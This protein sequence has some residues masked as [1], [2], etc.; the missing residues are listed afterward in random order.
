MLDESDIDSNVNEFKI[1]KVQDADEI[2]KYLPSVLDL[3]K[4][5]YANVEGGFFGQTNP[6]LLKK[7]ISMLQLVFDGKRII[8]G[9]MCKRFQESHKVSAMFCDQTPAG[10][11]AF[12]AVIRENI[13]DF[14]NW[15][16]CE[17][18][19]APEHYYKKFGGHPIPNCFAEEILK[20][21]GLVL[22]SDGFHYSRE[23][24]DSHG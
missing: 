15:V 21:T 6:A 18:S 10:K 9:A 23:I 20:K 24:G 1:V 5:S 22:N 17:V 16:W 13:K 3:I 19:G 11:R 4:L 2:A 12:Q 14:K 8:A 7:Q